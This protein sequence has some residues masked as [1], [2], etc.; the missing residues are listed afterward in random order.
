MKSIVVHSGGM[1]STVLLYRLV[2]EGDEVKALSIDYGQRHRKE[3]ACARA[4]AEATKFI[5]D[6]C[7]DLLPEDY[8]CVES[9]TRA[10]QESAMRI[11][12]CVPLHW[13]GLRATFII[14]GTL[15]RV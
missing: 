6:T 8:V 13:L 4:H 15:Y 7:L 11:R 1:D 9:L 12:I 14:N 2:A 3:I 10:V 5:T